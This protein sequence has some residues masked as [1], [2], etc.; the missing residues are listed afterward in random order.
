MWAHSIW[1]IVAAWSL[2]FLSLSFSSISLNVLICLHNEWVKLIGIFLSFFL[3]FSLSNHMFKCKS[4]SVRSLA[5]YF[6]IRLCMGKW[7]Q[8]SIKI[9]SNIKFKFWNIAI[10]T[11]FK[12]PFDN[13]HI[14]AESYKYKQNIDEHWQ[15]LRKTSKIY[16]HGYVLETGIKRCCKWCVFI[17][18]CIDSGRRKVSADADA[19]CVRSWW[20]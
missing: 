19:V 14:Y 12:R 15:K 10:H 1:F 9:L 7:F 11:P 13:I 3:F 20:Q 18:K 2:L 16:V 5:S 4:K 17:D 8:A 6:F